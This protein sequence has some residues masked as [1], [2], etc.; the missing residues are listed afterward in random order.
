MDALK[1]RYIDIWENDKNRFSSGINLVEN[2]KNFAKHIFEN[3][4]LPI[5]KS[6]DYQ[7]T[8]IQSILSLDW[9]IK[10][11]DVIDVRTSLNTENIFVGSFKDFISSY[12]EKATEYFCNIDEKYFDGLAALNTML[13]KSIFVIYVE[14]NTIISEPVDIIRTISATSNDMIVDRVLFISGDN[15]KVNI[16]IRDNADTDTKN[17]VFMFSVIEIF[18]GK[19]SEI[20]I[21]HI[22]DTNKSFYNSSSYYISLH[23]DSKLSLNSFVLSNGI[24]RNNFYCNLNEDNSSIYIN[25]LALGSYKQHIDNYSYINHKVPNCTSNEAFK[26]VLSDDSRG[27]FTGKIYVAKDSQKTEAYQNNKNLVISPK[28][29]MYSKPQ[30][31]IYADDVKCS[32]GMTT[33]QLDETAIFYMR[34]RGIP[35]DEAKKILTVAFTEDILK[36]VVVDRWQ[37]DIRE[38]IDNK[39]GYN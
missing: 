8:D 1:T 9:N 37:N 13:T 25:G 21:T 4:G 19:S 16:L 30:L 15:S 38:L 33:G 5:F 36:C 29:R 34:Q 22:E 11:N 20:S 24:T 6:E 7:K 14:E 31:E 26:Y 32:H 23:K 10:S 28:A 39:F 35:Y 12:Q 17:E 27:V 18:A 3:K 2:K